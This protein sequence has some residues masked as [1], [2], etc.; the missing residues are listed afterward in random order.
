M[1]KLELGAYFDP[2]N[3][4][5][6]LSD[7]ESTEESLQDFNEFQSDHQILEK[8]SKQ[9]Q[10]QKNVSDYYAKSLHTDEEKKIT[11]T[12]QIVPHSGGMEAK[13]FCSIVLRSLE[14]FLQI[15]SYKYKVIENTEFSIKVEVSAP[16][17][18]IDYMVGMVKLVR[19]SPFGKNDKIHTSFCKLNISE[20]VGRT[21]VTINENDLNWNFFKSTGPGGQHKNKTL[22]AVRLTHVPSGI[23]VISGNE[24]SQLDNKKKALIQLQNEL[25]KVDLNKE[26]NSKKQ[27]WQNNIVPKDANISLYFNH[28]L[29]TC[30][31]TGIQTTRLKDVLNGKWE[32]LK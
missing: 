5:I 14:K 17:G 24:R 19:V 1:F 29:V 27:G 2:L 30:E 23:V 20:K 3:S 32:L 12:I 15:K 18:F 7:V 22:T 13:D 26:L 9:L 8:F 10:G 16:K 11:Q 28:Q 25:E 21:Q 31:K 6:P 4:N